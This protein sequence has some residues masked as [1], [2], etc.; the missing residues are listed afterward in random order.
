MFSSR[1]HLLPN[2]ILISI[3]FRLPTE[4]P[5]EYTAD[6]QDEV[7]PDSLPLYS[8]SGRGEGKIFV[9]KYVVTPSHHDQPVWE[10]E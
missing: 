4:I 7:I 3:Q 1:G 9:I 5:A 8:T 2:P 10:K 6:V